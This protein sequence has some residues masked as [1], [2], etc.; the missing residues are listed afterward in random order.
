MIDFSRSRALCQQPSPRFLCFLLGTGILAFF[1]FFV[2]III[3]IFLIIYLFFFLLNFFFLLLL[4]LVLVF[5]FCL[6]V[7][8]PPTSFFVLFFS[9]SFP[10]LFLFLPFL[11]LI[12]LSSPGHTSGHQFAHVLL[13]NDLQ[14]AGMLSSLGRLQNVHVI[15]QPQNTI[16]S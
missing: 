11:H 4:L 6:F 13:K 5:L 15:L 9:L 10:L 3:I 2:I 7:S 1:F 14:T 12:L 16:Q 8:S